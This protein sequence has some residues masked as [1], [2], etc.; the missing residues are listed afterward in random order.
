MDIK[1]FILLKVAEAMEEETEAG[2]AEVIF[3]Y[4]LFTF[5]TSRYFPIVIV[6]SSTS[7]F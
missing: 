4:I 6:T 2:V 3:Y 1:L 7:N 5:I